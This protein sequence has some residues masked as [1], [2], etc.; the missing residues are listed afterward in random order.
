MSQTPG[1]RGK[2]RVALVPLGCPKNQVDAELMLGLLA[3]AGYEIVDRPEAAEVVIVNSCAFIEPAVEEAVEALLDLADFKRTGPLRALVCSGCLPQ[4]YGE[5]LLRELPEVDVFLGPGAVPRIAEAVALALAGQRRVL[6]APLDYLC[7]AETPRLRGGAEW[8]AYVKIADGCDNRCAYCVVPSLR[9]PYRSRPVADVR[10]E[11]ESLAAEGVREM[12]LIAQDTSAYGHDLHPPGTLAE[13]LRELGSLPYDGWLRVMYLHPAHVNPAL[14]D[15]MATA[16]AVVPYLDLPLQHA[17]PAVLRGMGRPGSPEAYLD[18]LGQVR[19][20]LPGAAIRT[21]F[22]VGFPGETEADFET[23]LAFV[24]AARFDRL[25]AFRYWPEEGTPAAAL[26]DQV[27]LEVG[28]ERLAAL[29]DVQEDLSLA[30]NQR[31]IGQ[32]LRVL[33]EETRPE[34]ALGRSYR[35]APEVD[36]QV[37]IA[38]APGLS[39]G[40]FVEV[41]ITEA[42]THDL[43]GVLTR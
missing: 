26:P 23:L 16:P 4:R 5:T 10:R 37:K 11:V 1:P 31:L 32:R 14:L 35:D 33:V 17:A 36:G 24:R 38:A 6:C 27:P 28:E 15:I 19:E 43:V 30:L 29:M 20:R 2:V 39:P 12:I 42:E 40:E 41:E 18:L 7:T 8:L 22:I 13:L 25:S 21:T 34:G 9:G 3:A